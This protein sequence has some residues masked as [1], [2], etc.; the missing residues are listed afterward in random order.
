[1]TKKTRRNADAEYQMAQE[2]IAEQLERIQ[3]GLRAHAARQSRRPQDW[4][5]NGDLGDIEA[6]LKR[7]GD[8][9]HGEGEY[10]PE[11]N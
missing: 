5:F 2:R 1:M 3:K 6:E 9:L 7:L 11:G 10:A 8:R 4:G